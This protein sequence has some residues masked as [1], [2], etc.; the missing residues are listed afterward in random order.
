MPSYLFDRSHLATDILLKKQYRRIYVSDIIS[1][2]SSILT[3]YPQLIQVKK[4]I[5]Q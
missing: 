2:D 4:G 1:L 3:T 5:S